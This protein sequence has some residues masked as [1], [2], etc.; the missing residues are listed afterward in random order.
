MEFG[1]RIR[2]IFQDPY[3]SSKLSGGRLRSSCSLQACTDMMVEFSCAR[4]SS[5]YPGGQEKTQVTPGTFSTVCAHHH[6]LGQLWTVMGLHLGITLSKTTP[7]LVFKD[8]AKL[9]LGVSTW[10]QTSWPNTNSDIYFAYL[11]VPVFGWIRYSFPKLLHG[12]VNQL[13]YFTPEM[14][15]FQLWVMR[16][17]EFEYQFN[18]FGILQEQ[19]HYLNVRLL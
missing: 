18:H 17:K 8:W 11:N 3:R 7:F 19:S 15:A 6:N 5:Q 4:I 1:L 2:E 14:A 12:A 9:L 13:Q 16:S 10:A